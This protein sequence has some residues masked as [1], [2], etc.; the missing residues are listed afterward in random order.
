M[1][2]RSA[3]LGCSFPAFHA[4]KTGFEA[5]RDRIDGR[6][7]LKTIGIRVTCGWRTLQQT[8]ST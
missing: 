7:N 2:L 1:R 4:V 5:D 6:G 3:R 8:L